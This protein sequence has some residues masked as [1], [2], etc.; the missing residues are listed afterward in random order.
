MNLFNLSDARFTRRLLVASGAF[1]AAAIPVAILGYAATHGWGPLHR[2]DS[3]V[4]T[5]LHVWALRSPHA[6]GFLEGVSTVLDPWSLRVVAL[7]GVVLL[8]VRGQRRM[9]L[10]AGVTV[11]VAGV[12]GFVLKLIVARSRPSLP[13]PVTAAPGSSFPSGH[14]LNSM[15]IIGVLVL[16]VLP[17]VPRRWRPFI[18][19]GAGATVALVG[20][21]RVAL[22]VH[23]VSDVLAG[24]LIGAGLIT[25]TVVAFE[26]WRRP[27]ARPAG[28]VLKEG[29]D[30]AGS[31]AAAGGA[32]RESAPKTEGG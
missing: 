32:K 3:G 20:F 23:Y 24:W 28:Q 5:N 17:T 11:A 2:L 10:W 19:A 31:R 9:A 25:V 7:G 27:D 21:A 22:G 6:V 30:P 8:A 4:A 1:V 13:D 18:W 12:T 14:A 29:V 16:L 26:T 15:A